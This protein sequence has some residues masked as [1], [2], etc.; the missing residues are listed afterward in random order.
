MT[1]SDPEAEEDPPSQTKEKVPGSAATAPAAPGES[2]SAVPEADAASIAPRP[3]EGLRPRGLRGL[4]GWFRRVFSGMFGNAHQGAKQ[5]LTPTPEEPVKPVPPVVVQNEA[6]L[7]NHSPFSIGFF[8]ALGVLVAIGLIVAALQVQNIL[9][10]VVLSLFL[11][12]GLSPAV[13]FFTRR[14]VPR[15]LAVFIVTVTLLGVFVLGVT[16]LF[17]LMTSQVQSLA[18]RVP[19]WIG[20]LATN[21]QVARWDA[22]Y[23]L[24]ETAQRYLASGGLVQNLFGGIWGASVLVGQFIFSVIMTLV[25]TIYFLASLP[26]IKEVIYKLAPGSRRERSRYLADEIF[27]GVSGYIT[28]MFMVVTVAAGCSFVFMNVVGLGAYSL[29]LAFIVALFCFIPVVGSWLAMLAVALVGFATSPTIGVATIIYFLIYQQFDAYVLYPTVMKRTVKV[30][31]A[32][33]VLSALIGASLLGIIGALIA[34]P[35]TAALL[36]L[37]REVLQPHLDAS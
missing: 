9:V 2:A 35:T 29:A 24:L 14:R 32:L 21:E 31:G 34:I 5:L 36:L 10:L 23:N 12:L 37:Y 33:V 16:A 7:L 20:M 22:Q 6:K 26:A 27:R 25:L 11:A 18:F 4:L 15:P 30:P 1:V 13:E 3:Q 28:G 17:P 19:Y 8:G